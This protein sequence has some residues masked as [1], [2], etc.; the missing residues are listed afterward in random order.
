MLAAFGI[1]ARLYDIQLVDSNNN[2]I[3]PNGEVR[4]ELTLPSKTLENDKTYTLYHIADN[5]A[6]YELMD[7]TIRNGNIEFYTTHFSYYAIVI[8]DK[9]VSFLWLWILLGVL[10]VLLLQAII[11]IIVKTRKYKITFISRGNIQVKSVKYKKDER[12]ILPKPERLGYIFGGWY[13][14]SKFS[15]PANIKTMPN[16]NIMLY[17]KWY[18]DPITIGLRVKKNK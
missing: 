14:D 2:P 15:Q 12:V 7:S 17:A 16:Q 10:G 4:V 1:V 13:I 3:E 18:E 5:L 11:I 6:E 9:V 8:S